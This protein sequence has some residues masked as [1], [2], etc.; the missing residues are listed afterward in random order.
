MARENPETEGRWGLSWLFDQNDP[1]GFGGGGDFPFPPAGLQGRLAESQMHFADR[2]T[3][4]EGQS[5]GGFGGGLGV[6]DDIA[7]DS[8]TNFGGM[9]P[10][11]GGGDEMDSLGPLFRT[12]LALQT[13]KNSGKDDQLFSLFSGIQL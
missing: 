4:A 8:L 1:V 7:A 12:L 11:F 10:L 9:F 5:G 13:G 2:P 6:G 3:R